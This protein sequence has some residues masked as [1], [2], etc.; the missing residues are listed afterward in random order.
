MPNILLMFMLLFLTGCYETNSP[1]KSE[2]TISTFIALNGLF[3]IKV[4]TTTT[5]DLEPY[6]LGNKTSIEVIDVTSS[7]PERC[8]FSDV[9]KHSFDVTLHEPGRCDYTYTVVNNLGLEYSAQIVVVP[10]NKE[11][12]LLA[13][14]SVPVFIGMVDVV[15][16]LKDM[17]GDVIK[18][19]SL[20]TDF[21][22]QASLGAA[23]GI[24]TKFDDQSIK[25][26]VP[27]SLGWNYIAYTLVKADRDVMIGHIFISIGNEIDESPKISE[28]TIVFP[29]KINTN[30][31]TTIDLTRIFGLI[32]KDK[33][34]TS[35][36]ASSWIEDKDNISINI[37]ASVCSNQTNFKCSAIA[38]NYIGNR[39]ECLMYT[40]KHSLTS[41]S[42]YDYKPRLL[43]ITDDSGTWQ[44]SDVQSIG[45]TVNPVSPNDV[46]N[47]NFT[48]IAPKEGSYDV[49]YMVSDHQ[50]NSA[51]GIIQ[52]N[53][54]EPSLPVITTNGIKYTITPTLDYM[55][56]IGWENYSNFIEYNGVPY[57]TFSNSQS[58]A[59]CDYLSDIR[60]DG[61]Y[62]WSRISD[63]D[64]TKLAS[65]AY[66]FD[67]IGDN[68]WPYNGLHWLKKAA[69]SP[70]YFSLFANS[71]IPYFGTYAGVSRPGLIFVNCSSR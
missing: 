4:N 61:E 70:D 49:I 55:E 69:F 1:P 21:V 19:Y 53:V 8:F 31:P 67:L 42:Q 13:P 44:L 15:I 54:V 9:N 6:I 32:V 60:F 48:F 64:A 38:F 2:E 10:S 39:R 43:N 7:N 58:V 46:N 57:A 24:A 27:S 59:W 63:N 26:Q 34:P 37:C 18:G 12:P 29:K 14:I 51:M 25:F 16:D 56:R 5:I 65:Y 52:F 41:S 62:N 17:L 35:S 28:P 36:A 3:T 30:T 40:D 23:S 45:A 11:N 50:N 71:D 33:I 47:K 20:D 66:R 22:I 68:D